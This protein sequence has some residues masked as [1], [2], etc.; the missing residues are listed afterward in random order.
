MI[1]FIKSWFKGR[2][3]PVQSPSPKG[4]HHSG[5]IRKSP[6][7]PPNAG[8]DAQARELTPRFNEDDPD[9]HGRIESVGPGKNVLVRNKYIREETG[10][11][12]TL[13]IVDDSIVDSGEATGLDPYNTGQF[14]R[15]K[16]WEQRFR[17]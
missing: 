2:S 10:T 12:D 8:D 17:K 13:K 16:K 5:Y 3:A 7:R 14:D 4:L 15:S 1:N 11:H 9:L 6:R